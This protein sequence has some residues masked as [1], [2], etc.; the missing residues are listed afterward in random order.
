MFK[1]VYV[2]L[3]LTII[4][5]LSFLVV[6]DITIAKTIENN[7]NIIS[8]ASVATVLCDDEIKAL[9]RRYW[10]YIIILAPL[11]LIVISSVE[12]LKAIMASDSDALNKSVGRTAKRVIALLILFFVP[13][14]VSII[15]GWFG[16][17]QAMCY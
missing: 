12:F 17:E 3:K 9:V 6:P 2:K 4:M 10:K 14:V 15:F 8:P 5:F 11:L 7:N 16:V 1:K 13:V